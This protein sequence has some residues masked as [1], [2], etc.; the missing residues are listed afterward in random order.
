M[1]DYATWSSVI[2]FLINHLFLSLQTE[3]NQKHIWPPSLFTPV[4]FLT[5]PDTDL[6]ASMVFEDE[7]WVVKVRMSP[8]GL[9]K[10]LR[11]SCLEPFTPQPITVTLKRDAVMLQ[12]PI[13]SGSGTWMTVLPYPI[14]GTSLETPPP[15]WSCPD[16][17]RHGRAGTPA[18]IHHQ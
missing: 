18:P 7:R 15:C 3:L 10:L 2:S 8:K 13:Y 6:L 12:R 16:R 4:W 11:L 14:A 9:L 1:N 5:A 17:W